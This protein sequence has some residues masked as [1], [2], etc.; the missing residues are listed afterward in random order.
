MTRVIPAA[1][2]MAVL[3]GYARGEDVTYLDRK[4]K[5][6]IDLVGAVVEEDGPAGLKLKLRKGKDT[7]TLT[8]A[9]ADIVQ[10]VYTSRDVDKVSFRLPFGKEAQGRKSN[11]PKARAKFFQEALAGYT[12]LDAKMTDVPAARRHLQLKIAEVSILIAQ[13][14]GDDEKLE[15]GIKLLEEFKQKHKDGW[16]IARALLLLARLQ[17]EQGEADKARQSYEELAGLDGVPAAVRQESEALVG[18]LLSRGGQYAEAEKR[19]KKL[20]GQL[21]PGD[22]Q[23]AFVR[24]YLVE[25][26][27]GLGQFDDAVKELTAVIKATADGRA[28]GVAYNLL[29]DYYLK[30]GNRDE[31]FWAYLRVDAQYNDDAEEQAKALYHLASLYDKVKNQPA[32]GQACQA[33]LMGKAYAH[34]RY[35]K[36]AKKDGKGEG[37]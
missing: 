32:R 7:E 2:L 9:A 8:V 23:M 4:A 22:P 15:K 26:R 3:L 30:R 1:V 31:A 11:S 13:D 35:H 27:M 25:A 33:R 19:L 24:A 17:E 21:S 34:T 29:G 12:A 20:S 14:E 10:V 36:L 28:R 16:Q 37:K 6:Q 18:R 5:K